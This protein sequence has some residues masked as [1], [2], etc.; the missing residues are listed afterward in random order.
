MY[1]LTLCASS[2]INSVTVLGGVGG[3]SLSLLILKECALEGQQAGRKLN[4]E[5][6]IVL[7][8]FNKDTSDVMS[9]LATVN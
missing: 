4:T 3:I 5:Q 1:V 7:S 9:W 8:F 6:H 2:Q